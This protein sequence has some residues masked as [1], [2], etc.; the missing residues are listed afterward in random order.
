VNTIDNGGGAGIT[1]GYAYYPYG[2]GNN[3]GYGILMNNE[4]MGSIGTA[5]GS[6]GRAL[7]HEM[8]HSL[9]LAHIFNVDGAATGCHSNDC[10]AN[11][12][13]SCDTPPQT[14]AS[15]NCNDTW[16][17]CN[18]IPSGD[19]FGTDVH[20]QIENYMSYNACQNMF[21]L[22]QVNIME[23]NLASISFLIS[24]V[25]AQNSIDTGVNDPDILCMTDFVTPI[26]SFCSGTT[27]T[28]EDLS[29]HGITD[30][31]WS[32]SPGTEGVDYNFMNGTDVNSQNPEIEFITSG[33]YDI[34]LLASDGVNSQSEIKSSYITVLTEPLTIPFLEDFESYSTLNN[35]DWVV[36]NPDN[37]D[38][39]ELNTT[40]GHT[41]TNCARL[42]SF[43]DAGNNT[44]ELISAAVDLSGLDSTDNI[45]MSFR[46]AYK[47]RSASSD[48]KLMVKTSTD[49]GETWNTKITRFGWQMSSTTQNS[50]WQPS[51]IND[52]TTQ[53]VQNIFVGEF[54]ENFR[55][56][57]VF[58]GET[59]N[60]FYLDNINIYPGEPTEDLSLSNSELGFNLALYPNPVD[61]ELN[62]SFEMNSAALA[63][64]TVM[65]VSGKVMSELTFAGNSGSNLFSIN[66]ENLAAGVY[67]LSLKVNGLQKVERFIVK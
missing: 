3:S 62:V 66:S 61:E 47:R 23:T 29:F 11:G 41:G 1:A 39:F 48:E 6:D 45:T 32:V 60:N 50:S 67:M 27:I 49:C 28:F 33:S 5:D 46:Y 54:V 4:Y 64:V 22:D 14:E 42:M 21:S 52:W 15:W 55:Y 24:L 20:D 53:H 43:G 26:T 10:Y 25:S 18:S 2:A 36:L 59:A 30:W 56:K 51:T 19:A 17:S 63:D 31:T 35:S 34:E 44:D 9:G 38:G 37:N 12:D 57:F 7:T 40:F 13:Y 58:E 8:G 16:N 65:D